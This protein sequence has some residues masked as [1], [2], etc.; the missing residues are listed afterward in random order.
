MSARLSR[1]T[2]RSNRWSTRIPDR[3]ADSPQELQYTVICSTQR[4]SV[5][6]SLL[7]CGR[8][9][10][11]WGWRN[12]DRRQDQQTLESPVKLRQ[13]RKSK[14]GTQIR[15]SGLLSRHS[16]SLDAASLKAAADSCHLLVAW[17][18]LSLPGIV[19]RRLHRLSALRF[20]GAP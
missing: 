10:A 2:W 11:R 4:S 18:V 3:N 8:D 12:Q 13:Y 6:G 19:R 20:V 15:W 9:G 17:L 1:S 5:Y 7:D 16:E 14:E